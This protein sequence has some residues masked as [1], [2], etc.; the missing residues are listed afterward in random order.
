MRVLYFSDIH[1]EVRE[2]GGSAPWTPTLP[3]GFGPDLS[4][5]VGGVEL[6]VLAGD[7]GRI[8]SSRNVS[9]LAYAEQTAAFLDCRVILPRFV[10]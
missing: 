2:R 4:S 6:L 8:Q 7:V 9:P 3:L 5:H 10:R 1:V